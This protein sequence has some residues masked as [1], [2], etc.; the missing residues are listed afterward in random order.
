MA[1]K[2][3]AKSVKILQIPNISRADLLED[4]R[5]ENVLKSVT[6]TPL[7]QIAV[8]G[9]DLQGDTIIWGTHADMDATIGL[10]ARGL[11]RLSQRTQVTDLGRDL[12]EEREGEEN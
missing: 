10:L 12:K 1:P 9:K 11:S 2:E 4:T 3:D 7:T 8:V 5:I 6:N